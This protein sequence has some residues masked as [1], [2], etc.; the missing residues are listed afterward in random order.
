MSRRSFLRNTAAISGTFFLPPAASWASA[1]AQQNPIAPTSDDTRKLFLFVDWYHVKKGALEVILEPQKISEQGRKILEANARDFNKTF[2]QGSAGRKRL[3][4]PYGVRIEQE[5]AT[6]S[7]PW[8]VADK[9]W[10]KGVS[11]GN[12]IRDQGRF[13]CWYCADLK[14]DGKNVAFADG[15]GMELS[16]TALAYAESQDGFNWSKPSLKV[17]NYNGSLENNLVTS[18]FNGGCVFQDDHAKPEERY[19]NFH[20]DKLPDSEI[21]KNAPTLKQYGLFGVT[22][23]DGYRWTLHSKPLVRHFSDTINIAGWD[24]LLE[25]YVG[26]FRCIAN[27]GRAISRS[28]TNDFWEWPHPEMFM[29]SGPLDPPSD[30]YYTNGYTPYP[31]DPSL[32]LLFVAVYHRNTDSVDVRVALSRD[33]RIF[34]WLSYQPIIHMGRPGEWDEG[35]VY[36]SPN[37][38]RLPDGHLALPYNGYRTTHDE[39]WYAVF[40]KDYTN[41]TSLAWA[42]WEDA[43]LAGIEAEDFGG[44]TTNESLFRGNQIEINARTTRGGSVEVELRERG[45]TIEGFSFADCVP[46]NGDAIW[47]TYKWKGKDNLAGLREKKL[48][49][50]IRLNSAKMFGYRFV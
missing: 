33:G 5:V 46:F 12:V 18:Y 45:K 20:F 31:D 29:A 43:R 36:A 4:I 1:L 23:P 49:L 34:Q 50:A 16:G 14:E 39:A 7:K 32:R 40:Y 44:L 19:K 2:T 8:L 6:K 37:L 13:R 9:P 27:G 41:P 28:E 38:V 11:C 42:M 3:D 30:D 48:E 15:R 17:Q 35:S 25:K 26:Y 47:T 21:P 24:P 10:E 22:S